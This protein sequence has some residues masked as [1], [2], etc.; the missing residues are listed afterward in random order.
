MR[1]TSSV[2]ILDTHVAVWWSTGSGRLSTAAAAAVARAERLGVPA[3]VFWEVALLVR[4][5]KLDLG[6]PVLEWAGRVLS[7]PR[8]VGL[9][10][11]PDIALLADGLD[12]HADPVDRFIVASAMHARVPLV[13]KDSLIRALKIVVTLW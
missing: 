11:T 12:M 9:P 3:I 6:M 7:I 10:L 4:K 5:R 2:I 1:T 8:I 13:T